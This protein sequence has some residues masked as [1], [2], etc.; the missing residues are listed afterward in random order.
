MRTSKVLDRFLNSVDCC[1]WGASAGLR[2]PADFLSLPTLSASVRRTALYTPDERRRR[3][4]SPW[5]LV[6]GV[7]APIQFL[8]FLVSL[9]LVLHALAT[10]TGTGLATLSVLVKTG[11][12]ATIMVTG[13]VW[14]HAVFG[15]WLFAPAF[16]W[17]DVVSL[18]VVALH[19]AYVAALLLGGMSVQQ[20]L[21]LALA[22]YASYLI[23]AAQYVLK[24]RLARRQG[25][26]PGPGNGA[27]ND[28]W[29]SC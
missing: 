29:G 10:N 14:E 22:A 20:Q 15:R 4:R 25:A 11:V 28:A 17:E 1:P 8:V 26:R 12:L 6:Q 5:T 7:L 24:L 3:D 23:N 16:L 21:L 9:F 27:P 13:S 2:V 18:L 19:A